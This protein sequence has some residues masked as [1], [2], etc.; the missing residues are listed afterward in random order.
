MRLSRLQKYI[1]SQCYF[2]KN[3]AKLKVEFYGFYPK[4]ELKNNKLGVQVSLQKSIDN[5]VLKDLVVAYG[6][7][8]ARKWYVNKVKLTVKGRKIAKEL[9]KK[10]QR[11]LPKL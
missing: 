10:R 5:L 1:L 6:H 9:I 11:K 2:N 7:K 3:K 4:K 8:T